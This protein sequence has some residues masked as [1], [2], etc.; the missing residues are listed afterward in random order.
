LGLLPAPGC[1]RVLLYQGEV[2]QLAP[3]C[4]PRLVLGQSGVPALFGFLRQVELKFL[5]EFFLPVGS[6]G[7]TEQLAK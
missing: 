1:A 7:E 5:A 6:S 3:G 2:A 4:P